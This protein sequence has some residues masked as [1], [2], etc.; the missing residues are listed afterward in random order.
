MSQN[1]RAPR[2]DEIEEIVSVEIDQEL[3]LAALDKQRLPAD[4]SKRAGRTVDPARD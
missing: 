4:R 1:V 3:S 2:A